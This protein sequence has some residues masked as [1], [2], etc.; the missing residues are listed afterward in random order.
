MGCTS[1]YRS[2]CLVLGLLLLKCRADHVVLFRG[3]STTKL[4]VFLV[5][6]TCLLYLVAAGLFTRAVWAFEQD[7]WQQ[8]IGA[9]AAE[10]G[11]GPGSYDVDRSVWHLNVGFADW[12][13]LLT[14]RIYA[15]SG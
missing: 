10:L 11:T 12:T 8:L 6:S 2:L 1:E 7:A 5:L 13:D 9:D 15:N 14:L 4:Q 3:G